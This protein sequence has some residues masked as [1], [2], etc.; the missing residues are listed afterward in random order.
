MIKVGSR[1]GGEGG[2]QMGK[3]GKVGSG[4][5]LSR[6]VGMFPCLMP[7]FY[8]HIL[9]SKGEYGT[10]RASSSMEYFIQ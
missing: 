8:F 5:M 6:Y 4:F 10:W 9:W 1:K 3:V 2:A 7:M